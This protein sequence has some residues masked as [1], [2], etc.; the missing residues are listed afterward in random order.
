V[1]GTT[2]ATSWSPFGFQH[3]GHQFAATFA[4][5]WPPDVSLVAYV[6]AHQNLDRIECRFTTECDGLAAFIERHK[7]DP[8]AHGRVFRPGW[9]LAERQKGY[10]FRTDVVKFA[11]QLF[12]PEAAAKHLP[13][14]EILVWFDAD[15]VT[16]R[17]VPE[18]F[19]ESLIGDADVCYLGRPGTHSEI[20][21]WAVRLSPMTRDFLQ[22]L[23][24]Q[25]RTDAVFKLRE[26]HSAFVWDYVRKDRELAGMRSRNLTPNGRNHVWMQSPLRLYLDHLKG[27]RKVLGRSPER[28]TA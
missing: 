2:I 10:S 8:A 4:A 28:R 1:T 13:D 15:V 9:R 23:A 6:E 22:L 5:L 11:T 27:K 24:D 12:I 26:W 21:F 16:H 19:I 20:G 25:Y 7:D 17:A 14:G 3:Y 18:G